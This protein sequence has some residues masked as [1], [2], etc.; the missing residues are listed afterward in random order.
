MKPA[1]SWLRGVLS[2]VLTPFDADGRPSIE[3]LTRHCRWLLAQDVGLALFGTNSEANSMTVNEKR[4]ILDELSA[5]GLPTGRMLP[6]TGACAVPDAIELTRHAVEAGCAGVLMLP[7]FYYKGVSDEGLFRAFAQVIEGVA[8]DRLRV[9]LYHIPPVT[10]VGISFAL[11]DR[12][13]A[14]FPGVIVGIKDSS[15]E[16]AN[17]AGLL[18]LFQQRGLAVFAGNETSLLQTMRAGGA[19]CVTATANVNPAGIVKLYRQWEDADADEQQL[20]LNETRAVFQSFPIIP[21]MKAAIGWKSG[22]G[23]WCQVRPPLV[24]LDA[25]QQ[26]LLQKRL[27]GIGFSI[28]DAASLA[29]DNEEN[30]C[31][32]DIS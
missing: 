8:D 2:P 21:A 16:W 24:E 25:G 7:P 22:D 32:A 30:T 5:A 26:A 18:E 29:A 6:G 27:T 13:M 17:T 15:G 11:I 1:T 19:G 10:Q 9:C 12:L 14:Q 28:P 31:N 3:R 4:H 23:Q 20:R